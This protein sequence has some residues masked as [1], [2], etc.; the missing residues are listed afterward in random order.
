MIEELLKEKQNHLMAIG[1]LGLGILCFV[2]YAYTVTATPSEQGK[3]LDTA[4][5]QKMEMIDSETGNIY[6]VWMKNG[7]WQ[8]VKALCDSDIAKNM[9]GQAP[10][11]EGQ[12]DLQ[13]LSLVG[14]SQ[15]S[16]SQYQK[17]YN[18]VKA[19]LEQELEQKIKEEVQS[20]LQ[21]QQPVYVVPVQPEAQPEQPQQELSAEEQASPEEQVSGSEPAPSNQEQSTEQESAEV[22]EITMPEEQPSIQ[23]TTQEEAP[24]ENQEPTSEPL[25]FKSVV[26]NITAGLINSVKKLW[27]FILSPLRR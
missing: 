14:G 18:Q 2:F 25:S 20:Q 13:Q 12:Q 10:G 26:F 6:C 16:Q 22:Q 19:Q 27:G 9:F 21:N 1:L 5:I 23:E 17:I 11:W 3:N 8:Q 4:R 15:S 7:Q 24:A